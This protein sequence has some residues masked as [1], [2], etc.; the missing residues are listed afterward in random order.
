[1][2]YKPRPVAAEVSFYVFASVAK[3]SCDRPI[4]W[5]LHSQAP[6]LGDWCYAMMH[7]N[8]H[9]SDGNAINLSVDACPFLMLP[10]PVDGAAS[11]KWKTPS[12]SSHDG[13]LALSVWL[14]QRLLADYFQTVMYLYQSVRATAA[15]GKAVVVYRPTTRAC[16]TVSAAA[17]T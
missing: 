5:R 17:H 14:A 4:L 3:C 1:M 6:F 9:K 2:V 7:I 10:S 11:P 13:S 15:A 16:R 12:H 8:G